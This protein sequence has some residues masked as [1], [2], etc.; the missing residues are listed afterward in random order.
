MGFFSVDIQEGKT[1]SEGIPLYSACELLTVPVLSLEKMVSCSVAVAV[2]SEHA[3][4]ARA[5][6]N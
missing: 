3:G 4:R 1:V 2:I 6:Q 5:R